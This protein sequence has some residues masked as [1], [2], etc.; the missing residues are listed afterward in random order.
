MLQ[1]PRLWSAVFA[2]VFAIV[3]VLFPYSFF[4]HGSFDAWF[5]LGPIAAPTSVGMVEFLRWAQDFMHFSSAPNGQVELPVLLIAG[6]VQYGALGYLIGIG[7]RRLR[8]KHRNAL[9]HGDRF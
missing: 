8:S 6:V 2:T 4:V 1:Q 5:A 7:F 3:W 9:A